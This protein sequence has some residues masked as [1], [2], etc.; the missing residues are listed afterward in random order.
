M[1]QNNGTIFSNIRIQLV[2][3]YF[4][5]VCN[6]FLH[7]HNDVVGLTVSSSGQQTPTTEGAPTWLRSSVLWKTEGTPG[8]LSRNVGPLDPQ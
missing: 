6:V 2:S 1:L 3:L 4:S 7:A 8:T 5:V